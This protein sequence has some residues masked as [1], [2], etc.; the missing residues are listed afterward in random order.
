MLGELG[1]RAEQLP[2]DVDLVLVPG[3]VADPD[4]LAVLPA[5]EVVGALVRSGHVRHQRR[6]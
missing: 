6:T 2:V 5:G 1:G 4:R 3:A